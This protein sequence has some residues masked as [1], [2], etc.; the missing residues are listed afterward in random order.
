ML[1]SQN[2]LEQIVIQ[3]TTTLFHIN[4]TTFI[5]MNKESGNNRNINME[6]RV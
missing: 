5:V 1:Y 2:S 3:K 6:Q 4:V